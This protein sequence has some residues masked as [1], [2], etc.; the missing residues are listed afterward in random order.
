MRSSLPPGVA[1][2]LLERFDV[3]EALIG[4]LAEEYGR[5]HSR[6]WFWR[7]TVVA[8]IKKGATDVRSHKRLAIRAVII[9]WMVESLIGWTTKQFVIPLLQGSW[10][11]RSEV[12]LDAQLGFRI[13]PLPFLITAAVGAVVTG[14][15]V[16]R[17]HRPHA[18]PMLL[19]YLASFLLF[20]VGGFVNSFDRGLR[21]FG[22]VYGLTFN[23]VFPFIVVPACLMLGGLL[24]AQ[25]HRGRNAR[26]MS[27]SA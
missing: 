21:A 4:D 14:W 3:D 16:A 6:A 11:W 27:A 22:G 10:S 23:S 1:N 7:Q 13:I 24:S 19:I 8:V 15:V 26:P 20:E 18:M 9:G 2:W 17:V 12:W 5:E 25:P